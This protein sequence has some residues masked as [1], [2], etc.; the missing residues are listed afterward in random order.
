MRAL[1]YDGSKPRFEPR[2]PDPELA[3]GEAIIRPIAAGVC[4]TDLEISRGYMDYRGVLGHEFV[5][6]VEKVHPDV[7]DKAKQ[8]VGKR[9]VGS[10]NCVCGKC[11][12][13]TRGLANHC[14]DRTVLGIAGRD[15]CFAER[16]S[17]PVK[18]LLA[19]PDTLDDDHAVFTE[20]LAAACNVMNMLRIE[21]RPFVTVL[22]DGRLGLL[23]AQVLS[24][25]NASVRVIGKHPDKLALCEK[26]GIKHRLLSDVSLRADQDVVVDCTGS[27]SGLDTALKMVRPRGKVVLKTT[28]AE[29]KGVDLSPIVIHE[30]QLLGSRCGLF[31]DAL[32]MLN[33][34]EVDVV[35]LI[36]RR[37]KF[38]E[39]EKALATAAMPGTL[40]VLIEFE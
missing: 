29:Q 32:A 25:L 6:I 15:G 35:S 1:V 34:G 17:L 23:T 18:N 37:V 9:V 16:F 40:K 11:D 12:M 33:G 27:A 28:V 10:I 26:W 24:K 21:S 30:I 19:V 22:G 13:C 39:S 8:L 2:H 4:S 38:A 3:P 31:S 7:D 20:P 5:G 36:S 14:R